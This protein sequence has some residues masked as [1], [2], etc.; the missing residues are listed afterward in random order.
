MRTM[1]EQVLLKNI[2]SLLL[3][4]AIV[5]CM[6]E[7]E[8][9][10]PRNERSSV[11]AS[12]DTDDNI[13][14]TDNKE[15]T[16]NASSNIYEDENI[17]TDISENDNLRDAPKSLKILA[18]GNSLSFNSLYYVYDIA[19]SLGIEEV[20]VG[21]LY[22]GSC[23][24][25]LHWKNAKYNKRAYKYYKNTDGEFKETNKVSIKKALNDEEWDYIMLSQY[26][27]HTGIPK[28][29]KSLNKLIKYIKR[30]TKED[31]EFIWNMLW[32]YGSNYKA[33]AFARYNYS[34]KI[35]YNKIIKTTKKKINNNK[36]ISMIIPSGTVIQNLRSTEFAGNLMTDGRHLSDKAC[37]A[38]GVTLT[39][40]ILNIDPGNI[41]VR[42]K[43]ISKKFRRY[44]I[45]SARKSIAKP[46]KVS[47]K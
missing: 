17:S 2:I 47:I 1:K 28:T 18:V 27:G 35:M 22:I 11:Y 26:S 12:E 13:V 41:K 6:G 37:Y 19:Q 38:V 20:V 42:P 30:Y 23:S 39:S 5:F 40:K 31:S 10:S 21:N 8:N 24:L 46:Y 33:N 32:S 43:G 15:V 9:S 16:K 25:K 29:Y 36:R 3:I 7:L 45:R 44:T 4:F 14:E 34:S